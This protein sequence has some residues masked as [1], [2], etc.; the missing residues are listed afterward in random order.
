MSNCKLPIERFAFLEMLAF[1]KGRVRNKDI[2]HQF[3]ITRQQAHKDLAKYRELHPGALIKLDKACFGFA[4]HASLS[5]SSA[6]LDDFF[7]WYETGY[8]AQPRPLN[9]SC[10]TR[11]ALPERNTCRHVLAGLINAIEQNLRLEVEYVSLSNPEDEGR[12]FTPHTLVKAG[13]RYH[14][15][16]YCEKSAA[17]RDLV[18]SRFRGIPVVEGIAHQTVKDDSAWQTMLAVILA[19]DPRLTAQQQQ[20]LAKDY[21]MEGGQLIIQCRAAL[22]DYLLREMQVNTKYLDG[23]PEAQ[24]L[25]LVNR[26]DI[27]QWLFNS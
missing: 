27:K 9:G 20:V 6:S 19:P 7:L 1:W 16:G 26:N 4:E 5:Y 13:S 2:E 10:A 15:R 24:Q 8:F 23:T 3:A 21:Q 14:V 12:I 17:F 25:V 11:M 22:V 18:L